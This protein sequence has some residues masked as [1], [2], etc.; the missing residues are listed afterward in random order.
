MANDLTAAP[1]VSAETGPPAFPPPD[2]A[3]RP[4]R[5]ALYVG[6]VLLITGAIALYLGYNGAAT[7]ALPQ[8]QTPY[9]I[10][11]G[12]VGVALMAVGGITVA[13]YVLL[14]VQADFRGELH[15]LRESMELLSEAVSHQAFGTTNGH[16]LAGGTVMVARSSSSYHKADC[17]LVERTEHARPMPRAEADREGLLPCRICKP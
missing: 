2:P 9:V 13:L 12:L 15:K 10:S 14:T 7:N 11:G 17:R 16:G 3:R 8:A 4:A 6:A 5:V 1:E